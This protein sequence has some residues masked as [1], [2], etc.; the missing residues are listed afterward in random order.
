MHK[1]CEQARQRARRGELKP[2]AAKKPAAKGKAK[3]NASA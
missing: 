1:P 2:K 3:K